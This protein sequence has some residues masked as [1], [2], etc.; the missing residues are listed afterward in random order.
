MNSQAERG[1]MVAG[2][3]LGAITAYGV[4]VAVMVFISLWM[5]VLVPVIYGAIVY[6]LFD[7]KIPA[8]G[9]QK[10]PRVIAFGTGLLTGAAVSVV[11]LRVD[12]LSLFWGLSLLGLYFGMYMYVTNAMRVKKSAK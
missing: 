12:Q 3:L 6:F 7:Y 10:S 8:G 9:W 2:I 1:P 11:M 4:S 5:L